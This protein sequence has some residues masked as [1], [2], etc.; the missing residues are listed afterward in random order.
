MRSERERSHLPTIALAGY[1]NAGKST[2]LN[3]LTGA[4]V[5]VG[6]RLFHT[7]DATTRLLHTGGRYAMLH[8]MQ[9]GIQEIVR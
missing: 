7:L 8:R 4:T 5:G 2:L 3:A 6:D 1:T 9:A